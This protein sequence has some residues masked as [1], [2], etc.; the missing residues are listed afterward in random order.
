MR[1]GIRS[2]AKTTEVIKVDLGEGCIVRAAKVSSDKLATAQNRKITADT[3]RTTNFS[4]KCE[5]L[6]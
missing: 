4:K 2:K 5:T 6:P 3:L 1:D